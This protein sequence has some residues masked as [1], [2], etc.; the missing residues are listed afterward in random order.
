HL[1]K[2][3][4][5]RWEQSQPFDEVCGLKLL[6]VD[7]TQFKTQ[8][9]PSNSHFGYAQ[10]TANFP[11]VLAVTLMSTRTH[12]ISDAAFGPVTNSELH[13]AQQLVGSAPEN[14]L[15]LFDR[16]FFSA[17]L[18]TSWQGV[19]TNHHW[20]TPI[21]SKMRYDVIESY[22]EYDHL[23]TMPVS[24]QA[25]KSASYLGDTWQARLIQ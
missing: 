25:K 24:P 5:A 13:Y 1:F 12:L 15:T 14:S 21:K 7:G 8:D 23:I 9:T 11:S 22:S 17:E 6:S 2:H 20:L 19:G 18:F 3:T 4:A 10:S 16:G